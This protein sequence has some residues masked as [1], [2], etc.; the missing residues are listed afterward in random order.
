MSVIGTIINR[1]LKKSIDCGAVVQLSQSDMDG[2]KGPVSYVTHHGVH[3]TQA[4][5]GDH[6]TP[7]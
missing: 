2:Y 6:T 7:V 1:E 4:R 3:S 5:L